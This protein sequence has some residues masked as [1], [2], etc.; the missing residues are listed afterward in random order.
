MSLSLRV[1]VAKGFVA[2]SLKWIHQ[3]LC[4][5]SLIATKTLR[6]EV[7]P[8]FLSVSLSLRV[9]VAKGFVAR[10]LK[11]IPQSLCNPSHQPSLIKNRGDDR[12]PKNTNCD[13]NT[14]FEFRGV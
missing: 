6:H 11:G 5:P 14:L 9:F 4:N 12:E 13:C 8:R 3:S 1:F 7:P 2:R 10:S